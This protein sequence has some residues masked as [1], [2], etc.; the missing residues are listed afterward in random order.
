MNQLQKGF[1][2]AV[3]QVLLVSSLGAKLLWDRANSPR[4]WALTQ[5][6]DP[7]LPIRGRYVSISLVVNADKVFPNL[8]KP[9]D[10]SPRNVYVSS[11]VFLTVENGRVVA[12]P[13]DRYTGLSVGS[14]QLHDGEVLATLSPPVVYFLPEH[15]ADPLRGHPRGTLFLEVTIPGKGPPRPIRFGSKIGTEFVPQPNQ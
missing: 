2:F 6:F 11:N 9:L 10:T 3:L 14:P 5:G 7:D 12:N 4:G 8:L 13:A 1:L 15:A